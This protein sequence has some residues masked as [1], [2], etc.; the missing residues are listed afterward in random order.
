MNTGRFYFDAWFGGA[1][2]DLLPALRLYIAPRDAAPGFYC[3]LT[4]EF[5]CC[6]AQLAYSRVPLP[7]ED[8]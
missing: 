2:I 7:P 5:L 3:H 6:R 4:A 1:S 8:A